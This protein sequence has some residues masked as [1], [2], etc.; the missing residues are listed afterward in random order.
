MKVYRALLACLFLLLIFCCQATANEQYFLDGS[1]T[2]LYKSINWWYYAS[3]GEAQKICGSSVR[4]RYRGEIRHS[5][6]ESKG[7]MTVCPEDGFADLLSVISREANHHRSLMLQGR[8][9]SVSPE[10]A[11]MATLTIEEQPLSNTYCVSFDEIE[12]VE[13]ER[14]KHEVTSWQFELTGKIYGLRQGKLALYRAPDNVR[15]CDSKKRQK[16]GAIRFSL[17]IFRGAERNFL[18]EFDFREPA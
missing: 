5:Y 3:A 4:Y 16:G 2:F 8:R 17:R 7:V 12:A 14:L 15:N 9:S 6:D 11:G 18:A 10:P 13:Y 1:Q